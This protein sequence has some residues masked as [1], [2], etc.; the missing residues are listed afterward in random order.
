MIDERVK[1]AFCAMSMARDRS[2]FDPSRSR[3]Q[4]D[5]IRASANKIS[6]C[7]PKLGARRNASTSRALKRRK[8]K[9]VELAFRGI[10]LANNGTKPGSSRQPNVDRIQSTGTL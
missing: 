4:N 1:P 5:F 7:V 10:N 2:Y 8:A 3:K 9:I 6:I